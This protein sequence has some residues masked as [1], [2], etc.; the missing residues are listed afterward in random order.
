MSA[1]GI[2][3]KL[4]LSEGLPPILGDKVQL[5][6]VILNLLMNAV[7]AMSGVGE[8]SRE[9]QINSAE[10]EPGNLL[11]AG[12]RFGPGSVSTD[13]ARLFEAFYTTK[14]T[15]L[16]IGLSICR[17]I[18]ESHGGRLWATPNEP[19]GAVFSMTLPIEEKAPT[20]IES[21]AT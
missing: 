14:S 18:V 9:L 13:T 8:G 1:N 20:K 3:V 16:G 7:E 17:S 10:G 11:V 6:Q 2:L 5:Q 4:Q 15:G 12:A 19:Q 21:P